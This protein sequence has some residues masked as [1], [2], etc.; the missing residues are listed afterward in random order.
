MEQVQSQVTAG[1]VRI[2]LDIYPEQTYS[3]W[4]QSRSG[5][6]GQTLFILGLEARNLEPHRTDAAATGT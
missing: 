1:G 3:F 4:R 5:A 2:T 6:G